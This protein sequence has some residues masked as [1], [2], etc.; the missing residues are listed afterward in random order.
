MYLPA[1]LWHQ[2]IQ[3]SH[4]HVLEDVLSICGHYHILPEECGTW[5]KY[6]RKIMDDHKWKGHLLIHVHEKFGYS[7]ATALQ[8]NTCT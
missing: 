2:S 1:R 6:I 4:V 7:D 3:I 5:A 8:V